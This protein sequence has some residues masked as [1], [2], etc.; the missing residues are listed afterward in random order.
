M[1]HRCSRKRCL[2]MGPRTHL[3]SCWL[4][5]QILPNLHGSV[6]Q[7]RESSDQTAEPLENI[8]PMNI[9]AVTDVRLSVVCILLRGNWFW[10][11]YSCS[12]EGRK[13]SWGWIRFRDCIFMIFRRTL[14]NAFSEPYLETLRTIKFGELARQSPFSWNIFRIW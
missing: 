3:V 8:G 14:R 5:I 6:D 1:P 7:D 12:Y 10:C 11:G 9:T 13:K 4:L 2:T